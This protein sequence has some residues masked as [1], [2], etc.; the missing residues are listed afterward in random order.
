MLAKC[1]SVKE[2]YNKFTDQGKNSLTYLVQ[3]YEINR[4]YSNTPRK[5]LGLLAWKD[6]FQALINLA[7]CH[8]FGCK[9]GLEVVETSELS[10]ETPEKY[11]S[12]CG[13][14]DKAYSHSNGRN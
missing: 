10:M 9:V 5:L 12:R 3:D 4:Y 13:Y 8:I 11:C 2:V 1:F 7:I 14:S 6:L